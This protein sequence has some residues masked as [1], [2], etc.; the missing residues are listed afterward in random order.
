MSLSTPNFAI[1]TVRSARTV[2]NRALHQ[3]AF[4]W[5]PDL[6]SAPT[7]SSSST[8][9]SAGGLSAGEKL[10]EILLE[11]LRKSEESQA[12]SASNNAGS[13]GELRID[14]KTS[15]P[16]CTD[17]LDRCLLNSFVWQRGPTSRV[18]AI[19]CESGQ[20]RTL[21]LVI[22]RSLTDSVVALA[23]DLQPDPTRFRLPLPHPS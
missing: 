13:G 6:N 15:A 14:D 22:A 5:A 19:L 23:A 10:G 7:A 1:S 4:R 21:S 9:G 18:P 17:P 3:T 2:A 16:C 11:S 20:R 12:K 8:S